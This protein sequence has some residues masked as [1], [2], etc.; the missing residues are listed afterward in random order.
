MHDSAL[1]LS[2]RLA[3]LETAQLIRRAT[4]PEAALLCTGTAGEC[5][6]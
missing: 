4:D 3:V 1:N 5:R 6:A 2:E